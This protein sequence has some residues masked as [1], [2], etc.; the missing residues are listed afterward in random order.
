MRIA[1]WNLLW[2]FGDWEPRQRLIEE[3]L[4]EQAP[5]L[6]LLQETWPGQAER[7]SSMLAMTVIAFEGGYFDQDLSSVPNDEVFGNAILAKSELPVELVHRGAIDAPGD[8]AP[9][10]LL[11]ARVGN[12]SEAVLVATSHLT[13]IADSHDGREAQLRHVAGVLDDLGGPA[14]FCGDLN[15]I[16]S[17][18]EHAVAESLG[19][20]DAWLE[21]HPDPADVE[22]FG[23]TMIPANAE[24]RFTDW[25]NDRNGSAAP[26]GSGVRLDYVWT[27]A[28]SGSTTDRPIVAELTRFGFGTGE[29]WPSD[30]LGLVFELTPADTTDGPG[31][32]T[33]R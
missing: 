16:P 33:P 24:I 29:R 27:R 26:P 11:V 19:F 22:A 31:R 6:V 8:P 15:L 1:T 28:S 2:R 7:L 4:A 9:R 10:N 18:P 21:A 32:N 20:V 30:H 3:G 14:V 13:H 17:S 23:A 25:M 12:G 5:D